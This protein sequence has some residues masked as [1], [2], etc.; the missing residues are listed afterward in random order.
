MTAAS[1]EAI[2]TEGPD[3]SGWLV[4]QAD[5]ARLGYCM[6]GDIVHFKMPFVNENEQPVA[7]EIVSG[8]S[9]FELD[10]PRDTFPT[11][12]RGEIT[13]TFFSA[14]QLG[15]HTK[16]VDIILRNSDAQGYPIVQQI[17]VNVQVGSSPFPPKKEEMQAAEKPKPA[18]STAKSGKV[19]PAGK[20][21]KPK[22][23]QE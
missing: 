17:R 8:C 10:W 13:G 6:E 12:G 15:E 11:G 7:I 21:A 22:V 9:C 23:K 2:K 5:T 1:I 18:S 3:S 19:K 14:A 20:R 4:F 16:T